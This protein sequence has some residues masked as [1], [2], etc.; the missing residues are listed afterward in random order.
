MPPDSGGAVTIAQEFAQ[1]VNSGSAPH[2]CG[3]LVLDAWLEVNRLRNARGIACK[4]NYYWQFV[5]LYQ[6]SL[7]Q[8]TRR[9]EVA[10]NNHKTPFGG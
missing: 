10:G 2:R 1:R 6:G 3:D 9:M 8:T 5:V 7:L 4:R